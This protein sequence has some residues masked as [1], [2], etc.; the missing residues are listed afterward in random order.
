M[1]DAINVS[2]KQNKTKNYIDLKKEIDLC[3]K[4]ILEEKRA[5]SRCSEDY[6]SCQD[7]LNSVEIKFQQSL[8]QGKDDAL[9]SH[10]LQATSKYDEEITSIKN[11]IV[12]VENKHNSELDK[13]KN[14]KIEDMYS[15]EEAVTAE[16]R[17]SLAILQT[18]LDKAISPRFQVELNKQLDSQH[19]DIKPEDIEGIISY[20]NKQS[21]K[22]ASLSSISFLDKIIDWV[23]KTI[24]I[25][26]DND[27]NAKKTKISYGVLSLLFVIV[28]IISAK[29]VFPFY[30][31][32]LFILFIYNLN[33]NYKIYSVMMAQK[34]INDNLSAVDDNLRQKAEKE[35][36]DRKEVL[37]SK[38]DSEI[39]D[40][41]NSLSDAELMKQTCKQNA[42]NNFTFDDS[43]I[44][45]QYQNALRINN[46]RMQDIKAQKT[47]HENNI[48]ALQEQLNSLQMEK[49]KAVDGIQSSFLD[50]DTVGT[51]A[52]LDNRFIVDVI[53]TTPKYFDHPL[54]GTLFLYKDETDV[55]NFIRLLIIQLRIKLIPTSLQ[56]AIIDPIKLGTAFL[57]FAIDNAGT[58]NKQLF[59]ILSNKQDIEE[60]LENIGSCVTK[61]IPTIRKIHTN[62]NEYNM[63]MLVSDSLP[64][65]YCFSFLINPENNLLNNANFEKAYVNG[66]S[67]GVNTHVF[68]S[69][70]D[71]CESVPMSLK[72]IQHSNGI[73]E[74]K[75]GALLKRAKEFVT[76]K[77]MEA[78]KEKPQ[79]SL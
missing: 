68:I 18:Q 79:N 61:R 47:V 54:G 14:A 51:N 49:D 65:P 64:E 7:A 52:I 39:M 74:L 35:L 11:K 46:S 27:E 1:Q 23:L 12:E 73:Y 33:K 17:A 6:S 62:I 56:C 21:N 24:R 53:D 16:I 38:Y 78:S 43:A 4:N 44:T 70:H 58:A 57:P 37:N 50:F 67:V 42:K 25:K 20:F 8:Q 13:I 41:K 36:Q 63:D 3:R 75:D 9:N 77:L 2:E 55:I 69:M 48:K 30:V 66:G 32:F 29:Y 26:V 15:G 40:L 72:L 71:F 45:Q 28:F 59:Q 22:L 5:L 31:F 76:E 34:V 10:I 60:Y 19:I